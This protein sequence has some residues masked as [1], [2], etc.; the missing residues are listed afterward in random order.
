MPNSPQNPKLPKNHDER[1][2]RA[3]W[4][5]EGLSVAD[6]LGGFFEFGN[7]HNLSHFIKT[8]TLPSPPWRWTDDTSMALS[9]YEILRKFGEINQDALATSFAQHFDRRRGYGMGAR[10]LLTKIQQGSAWRDLASAMF[11]GT[12]SFG[13]GSGMRIA[14]LGAYFADDLPTLVEQA[15]L[16]SEITHMHPEGI[17]GGIAT[18]VATGIAWQV[19]GQAITRQEFIARILPYIPDSGVKRGIQQ[20]HDLPDNLSL[21]DVVEAIGNG[22]SVSSQDTVPFVLWS[23]GEKL[24][25]YEEA[26]WQTMSAGGDVDTTSAMVGGIVASYLGEGAIPSTWLEHRES[27]PDW[28]FTG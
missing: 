14:P 26:I 25:D 3:K 15:K 20:A 13:N 22:S 16:A 7:P 27:L 2:N 21:I 23:A 24:T 4:A 6:S 9:I 11:N 12:G 18:A 28:A 1:L 5:L 19:R 17:A 10:V 8:R